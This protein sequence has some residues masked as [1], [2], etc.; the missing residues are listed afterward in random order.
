MCAIMF[1]YMQHLQSIRLSRLSLSARW[2]FVD[3]QHA[4][5]WHNTQACK[6]SAW[7]QWG[8]GWVLEV[9]PSNFASSDVLLCHD[10]AKLSQRCAAES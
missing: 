6:H 10:A 2:G 8:L 9:G 1:L 3:A 7:A 5:P 4:D